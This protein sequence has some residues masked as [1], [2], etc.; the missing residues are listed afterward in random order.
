MERVLAVACLVLASQLGVAAAAEQPPAGADVRQVLPVKA[1]QTACFTAKLAAPVPMTVEDWSEGAV[2]FEEV[3]GLKEPSGKPAT[4]PVPK[5]STGRVT[6]LVLS[7]APDTHNASEPYRYLLS[8]RL[9][10]KKRKLRASGPCNLFDPVET[11]LRKGERG[12]MT[13]LG[14][15]VECDG[16]SVAVERQ[17]AEPLLSV[18]FGEVGLRMTPGCSGEED[19]FR[20]AA[21]TEETTF[22]LAPADARACRALRAWARER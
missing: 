20:L 18:T 7:L 3:P 13:A 19:S 8:A 21:P 9:D 2:T 16:G 22:T 10:G 12:T 11:G 6:G 14:C 4:R 15:A 1:G 17:G 5:R